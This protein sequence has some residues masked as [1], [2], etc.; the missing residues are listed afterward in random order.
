MQ[1]HSMI[2][3]PG[4]LDP[5][6]NDLAMRIFAG[7]HTTIEKIDAVIRHFRE[8]YSYSLAVDIPEDQDKLTY[9]LLSGSSGYCEYFASG[10]AIL[11]RL[12]NVPTRYVTGFYVT[13]R[14]DES[15]TWIARNMDAHAW[16]EAWDEERECWTIVEATVQGGANTT[17]IDVAPEQANETISAI[18]RRLAE[19][20]YQYGVVGLISWLF[21]SYGMF[22]GA[23]AL[24]VIFGCILS[25]LL[26]RWSGRRRARSGPAIAPVVIAMH[27]LLARTDRKMKPMGLRRDPA[28]TLHAFAA[29]IASAPPGAS[30][31]PQLADSLGLAAAWYREY[32]ALRYARSVSP[33][34]LQHLRQSAPPKMK[35]R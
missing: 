34:Q 4:Q 27:R 12:A 14:G 8:H 22:A 20:V 15:G 18:F 32:S 33:E 21:T 7:C 5:R 26:F 16:A 24:S 28:E 13:Q 6:V 23:L 3:P 31:S 1:L 30:A 9:F 11:L 19:D 10:A 29:R 35:R 17:P 2:S 25:W